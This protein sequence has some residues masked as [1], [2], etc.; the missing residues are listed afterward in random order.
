MMLVSCITAD[1]TGAD[2]SSC[3]LCSIAGVHVVQWREKRERLVMNDIVWMQGRLFRIWKGFM[4]ENDCQI[5]QHSMV[6]VFAS[7]DF[8]TEIPFIFCTIRISAD[9]SV[10]LSVHTHLCT[11][12]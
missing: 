10:C 6:L 1:S 3:W 2:A 8:W 9:D 12:A 7:T 11:R 5:V 4:E